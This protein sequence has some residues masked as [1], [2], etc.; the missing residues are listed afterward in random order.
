MKFKKLLALLMCA[1]MVWGSIVTVGASDNAETIAV[2][3]EIAADEV[4]PCNTSLE[5]LE[6]INEV[7]DPEEIQR[8]VD[9]GQAHRNENGEL[10]IAIATY[11]TTDF[12]DAYLPNGM[13][14]Y[15]A[16]DITITK[17]TTVDKIISDEYDRYEIPGPCNFKQTYS[18]TSDVEWTTSMKGSVSVGGS[19]FD[20]AEVKAAV[21]TVGGYKVGQKITKTSLYEVNIADNTYWEIKVWTNYKQFAYTAKYGSATLGNGTYM[22]PGGLVIE[23]TIYPL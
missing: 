5:E 6:L 4:I 14:T 22:Y 11:K 18:M 23:R 8:L 20:V 12:D 16:S 19:I 7:T 9:A 1:V 15:A 21:E 2:E 10:P 17:G 13:Q 3:P